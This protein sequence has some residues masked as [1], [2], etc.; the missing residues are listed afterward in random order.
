HSVDEYY[1]D[2][3]NCEVFYRCWGGWQQAKFFCGPGTAFNTKFNNCDH[4]YNVDCDEK[5]IEDAISSTTEEPT[6]KPEPTDDY[7][8]DE[9]KT[10]EK[11]EE[12]KTDEKPDE[13]KTDEK[14][15]EDD[16]DVKPD[17]NQVDVKPDEYRPPHNKDIKPDKDEKPDDEVNTDDE[18]IDN[19]IDPREKKAGKLRKPVTASKQKL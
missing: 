3:Q 18:N 7:V 12:D 16:I 2:P 6:E 15:D 17:G 8:E 11:P 1:R 14:P 5:K 13:D 19:L 4:K 10:D 9:D